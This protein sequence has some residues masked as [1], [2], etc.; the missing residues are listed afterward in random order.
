MIIMNPSSGRAEARDYIEAAETA[1]HSAGYQV[2]TRETA[3]EGDAT[4]FCRLACREGYDLVVAVGG[5][6]TL[7]ETMNGLADQECRPKLAV[8]PMGTVND[9]ARALQIPLNPADAVR[10]LSSSRVQR[11]DMGRLN[12]RLFVNVV[13]AGS[14]AG[15]LSSVTSEDK[16]RLGFL[17]YLK[18]GIKELT[19]N[20]VHP[21]RITYDG[22]T[23][24]G[25]S[26][27][28]LAA[29]TNS[30]GGFEKLAPGA[31]VDD[32]LL[33]C[34]I[35]KDLHLLNSVTVSISLLLGNL[36]NHK[37]VI[38]FTARQVSVSSADPVKTN[39][40]G[41][42][43]PPLPITLSTIPRHIEVVVPEQ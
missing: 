15:S 22:E 20:H 36:R 9:F 30:V 12:D 34:F 33:H 1:L 6:G 5:D 31:A 11:V 24:E 37:D 19:G 23:W 13:A 38:Y 27:L 2:T 21:L 18:E 10:T 16:T 41:E 14:L 29:L 8:V 25:S 28:F 39:V 26:P 32:G 7:H 17:A 43:G 3:A 4:A 35:I 42:E 40:D